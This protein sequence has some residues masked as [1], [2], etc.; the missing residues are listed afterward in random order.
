[1]LRSR[2]AGRVRSLGF[3]STCYV[4]ACGDLT[5]ALALTTL[6][7]TPIAAAFLNTIAEPAR[8]GWHRYLAWTVAL[9]PIPRDWQHAR[10]VLAPIADRALGGI[11]PTRAELFT[12][13][14][15]AYRLRPCDMAPLIAWS[16]SQPTD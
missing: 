12:A 9:L 7:N 14:C 2:S 11:A 1:M 15:R 4:I 5:D 3:R 10:D 13:A 8:G 16:Q 6:L